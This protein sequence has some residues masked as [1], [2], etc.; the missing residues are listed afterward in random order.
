MRKVLHLL[1]YALGMAYC[2]SAVV[3]YLR[4]LYYP[5]GFSIEALDKFPL[6]IYLTEVGREVATLVMITTVSLLSF[7]RV[8]GRIGS[9]LFI[10]GLWDIFYYLL[11]YLLIHWPPS[12]KTLDVL[13]LIPIPWIAPV[14]IPVAIASGMVLVGF[15]LVIKS[16]AY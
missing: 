13:F 14:Y 6:R 16:P 10:F 12:L 1:L 3:A 11:L 7:S 8:K 15:F 2:E 9:F 4:E 5:S